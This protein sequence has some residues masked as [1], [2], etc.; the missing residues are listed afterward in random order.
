M[1][2]S[3]LTASFLAYL[4]TAV[5]AQAGGNRPEP[6]EPID[7]QAMIDA[8]WDMTYDQRLGSTAATRDGIFDSIVCLEERILEQFAALFP[9]TVLSRESAARKLEITRETYTDLY[10]HIYNENKGCRIC[11]TQ[12]YSSD[13]IAWSDVLERMLKDAVGQRNRYKL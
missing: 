1:K 13:L 2:R 4:L 11:P 3:M 12:Y 6:Y 7:A 8:C 9:A 5:P 10:W